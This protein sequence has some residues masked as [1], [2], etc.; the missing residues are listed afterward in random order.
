MKYLIILVLTT[1]SVGVSAS[2]YSG[3]RI[4]AGMGTGSYS[5]DFT[6]YAPNGSVLT[7]DTFTDD[8]E[9]LKLEYG[10]DFNRVVSIN[11]SYTD[12][13]AGSNSMIP[14]NPQSLDLTKNE[15][16]NGS[17]FLLEGEVG[18]AFNI[19]KGWDVK[20]YVAI[21]IAKNDHSYSKYA[22]TPLTGSFDKS[23]TND[24]TTL[25]YAAGARLTTPIGIYLDIRAQSIESD[26]SFDDSE[27]GMK[28]DDIYTE[29]TIGYKF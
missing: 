23:A 24:D 15:S 21:G 6:V 12:V 3:H 25:N 9:Y 4:G 5:S 29:A 22:H 17:T 16:I 2:D 19:S 13:K 28:I 11:A 1:L 26:V 14:G 10:Y 20:P 7:S 18:Y 8:V 27:M